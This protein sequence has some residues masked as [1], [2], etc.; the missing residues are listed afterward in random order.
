MP[1]FNWIAFAIGILIAIAVKISWR[2]NSFALWIGIL[3]VVS[4]ILIL[5]IANLIATGYVQEKANE[6]N[7]WEVISE[8]ELIPLT[9]EE[10]EDP[11]YLVVENER[12]STRKQY[13]YQTKWYEGTDTLNSTEHLVTIVD[14]DFVTPALV[15]EEIVL[16]T[17]WANLFLFDKT[18][19]RYNF[20]L[21]EYNVLDVQTY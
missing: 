6:L 20:V 1:I 2:D 12:N 13:I 17:W 11:I 15:I 7:S 5:M 8:E 9:E 3:S 21:A 19:N 18:I 16:D 4:L 14:A 10:E